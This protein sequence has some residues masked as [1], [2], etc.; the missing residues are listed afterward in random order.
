MIFSS[1]FFKVWFNYYYID[2]II[3]IIIII[4]F[5]LILLTSRAS[6][7][8]NTQDYNTLSM[9]VS[10]AQSVKALVTQPVNIEG[11]EKY[12]LKP[13]QFRDIFYLIFL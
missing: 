2:V 6:I 1:I 9:N 12:G 5:E 13:G 4:I 8:L 7:F 11:R 10:V 3:I